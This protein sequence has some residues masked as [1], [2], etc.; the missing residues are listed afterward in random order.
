MSKQLRKAVSGKRNRLKQHGYDLDITY[1]TQRI[2]AMS[3]P[4]SNNTQKLYRNNIVTVAK[5]LDERH[6]NSYSIFNVSNRDVDE[7]KF[8]N[9]VYSYPWEDHHSPSLSVLFEC[10]NTMFEFLATKVENVA[11]VHCN[12]GKGRTGTA[13]ACFLIFSGLS[14]NFID[15]LTYYGH[16]RFSTGRGT[17]QP[18]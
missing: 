8:H 13:I 2:L 3:F 5:F 11:V 16:M 4:A 6:S 12:A 14:E 18:A 1:I 15:A 7:P 10:C 9:R 17:T